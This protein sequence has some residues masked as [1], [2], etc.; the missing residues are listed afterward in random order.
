[1]G[2]RS[3]SQTMSFSEI[4]LF[5]SDHG[6]VPGKRQ[7]PTY[8]GRVS[9][10]PH[11]KGKEQDCSTGAALLECA[12]SS[13]KL[14]PRWGRPAAFINTTESVRELRP[15]G[16]LLTMSG[17][18]RTFQKVLSAL[19]LSCGLALSTN[20]NWLVSSAKWPSLAGK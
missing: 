16:Y 8:W 9:N 2:S 1:M 10:E 17:S 12:V 13:G 18:T 7:R 4:E 14:I 3:A 11:I 6:L 5:V 20:R 19:I 15:Q